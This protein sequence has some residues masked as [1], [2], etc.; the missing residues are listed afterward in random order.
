MPVHRIYTH[1][2]L[3]SIDL[4]EIGVRKVGHRTG[5]PPDTYSEANMWGLGACETITVPEARKEKKP[6]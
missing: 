5:T 6:K 1:D 4:Y 2:Q 3:Y